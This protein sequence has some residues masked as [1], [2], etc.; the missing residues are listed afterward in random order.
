MVAQVRLEPNH[1]KSR[2]TIS[3][4]KETRRTLYERR[5]SLRS[6]FCLVVD[7]KESLIDVISL[8]TEGLNAQQIGVPRRAKDSRA[9]SESLMSGSTFPPVIWMRS[10]R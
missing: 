5:M 2:I 10:G 3:I 1:P 7:E 4:P 9:Q 8:L 6:I